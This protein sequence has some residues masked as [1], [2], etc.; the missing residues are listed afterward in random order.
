MSKLLDYI[1]LSF[2]ACGL[3]LG[4]QI[5]AFVSDFGQA[6]SAQLIE[7]NNAVAPFKSDATKYFNNDLNK[8]IKHYQNIDDEIVNKGASNI[9]T[10]YE[11][12]QDLQIAVNRFE[13]SPYIFTMINGMSDIKQQVW[14]RFE[15]QI[16]LKKDSII[17]AIVAAIIVAL[18]AELTGYLFLTGVKR[19]FKRLF[20]AQK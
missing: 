12:Q 10:L 8:L 3:L 2:F 11:R 17:A 6:L 18:L 15:G 5:P 1:R 9:S 14:Q 20:A 4:V 19:S 16:I 7:A 13:K